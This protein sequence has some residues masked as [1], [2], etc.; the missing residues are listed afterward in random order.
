MET[1]RSTATNKKDMSKAIYRV[2]VARYRNA[3]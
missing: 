3:E 2:P 1:A